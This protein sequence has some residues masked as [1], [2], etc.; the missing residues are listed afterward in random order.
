M[1]AIAET[2]DASTTGEST[3]GP[4]AN[5]HHPIETITEDYCDTLAEDFTEQ[6]V[7]HLNT[8]TPRFLYRDRRTGQSVYS[9]VA[10]AHLIVEIHNE[11]M[12]KTLTEI[13]STDGQVRHLVET[14]IGCIDERARLRAANQALRTELAG[15]EPVYR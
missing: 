1:T 11:Q 10:L 4:L 15:R 6:V 7:Q 12:Q 2:P 13:Q 9:P 5:H 14:L 8:H 3:P